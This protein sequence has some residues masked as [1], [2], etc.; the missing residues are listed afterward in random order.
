[1]R[2]KDLGKGDIDRDSGNPVDMGLNERMRY[3]HDTKLHA[4][5]E[6]N[7]SRPVGKTESVSSDRGTFKSRV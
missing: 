3:E 7:T 4:E 1:M 2:V 5:T 6:G